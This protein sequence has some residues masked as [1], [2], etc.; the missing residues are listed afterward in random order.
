MTYTIYY[1]ASADRD[2]DKAIDY[3]LVNLKNPSAALRLQQSEQS[4]V[5]NLINFPCKY[6]IID[7]LLLAPYE[8]RFIP[9][10]NYLLF[11][12]ITEETKTIYI[13]R[14]LYSRSDWQR[15]LK[16]YI[17]YD[18]YL[19]ETTG[20]YVHE[21]QEEYGKQIKKELTSKVETTKNVNNNKT[22]DEEAARTELLNELKKGLDDIKAGRTYSEEEFFAMLDEIFEK[23][24]K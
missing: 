2:I 20:G 10:Q 12:T 11:Y 15:I 23:N 7:D 3:I 18:Q 9:I 17:Q 8:I 24:T 5:G 14:F 6:P 22:L 21:E 13:I 19:S 4:L 16:L 1:S